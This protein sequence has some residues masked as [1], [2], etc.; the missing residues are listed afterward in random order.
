[1]HKDR[2]IYLIGIIIGLIFLGLVYFINQNSEKTNQADTLE[3]YEKND[4][5]IK[6]IVTGGVYLER[7]VGIL[8]VKVKESNV[9]QFTSELTFLFHPKIKINEDYAEI[10]SGDF[11]AIEK[12]DSILFSMKDRIFKIYRRDSLIHDI[13]LKY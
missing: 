5:K 4:I 11:D 7:N 9:N 1:M 8:Y 13:G 6:G 2:N 10:I 3:N 12:K